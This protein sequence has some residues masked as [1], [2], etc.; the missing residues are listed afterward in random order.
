MK[1]IMIRS[2]MSVIDKDYAGYGWAKV[3]FSK[4][5]IASDV[6]AKINEEYV[7][8]IGRHSNSIKR[9]F[10]LA[11]GDI[12]VVPLSKAIAIGIVNGKKTFDQ[13]LAKAKACNLISVNF[14]RTNNG[15]ILRIPR[16]SLTQGLESRLKVRKSNTN[17][18]DF[19]DEITRIVDSIE[20]NGAYKQET[21]LLEKI[22]EAEQKFKTDLHA[23]ITS[24][25][26]WLSAGGTGLEQLVKE[27]LVIE[28]YTAM[29]QPKNQSSDI[30]DIDI[31]ANRID[32]FSE[33]NLLIQVKHHS[34]ISGSHGLKQLIAFDDFED[35]EYQKWFITTADMTDSSLELASQNDIRVMVGSDFV[36]WIYE[37]IPALS[38]GTKQQL[39]IIEIP[40][41]LK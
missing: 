33:S 17:L 11:A 6:I 21:Y 37:N 23:S 30:S 31:I 24:G 18:S 27:L 13:N 40:L 32:R 9:F 15:H 34:N 28:G 26:T 5:E 14:F 19:K 35:I 16:K 36:D 39:G 38:Y 29:I 12:V 2:P 3:D 10:N 41:L 22:S 7:D 1:V 25:T 4:Y 20:S 8:G